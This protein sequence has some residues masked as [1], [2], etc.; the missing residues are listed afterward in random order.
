[1]M[2]NLSGITNMKDQK[3]TNKKQDREISRRDF[4][5]GAAAPVA[6]FTAETTVIRR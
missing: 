6:A 3:K 2:P 1:M 5:G 4:M